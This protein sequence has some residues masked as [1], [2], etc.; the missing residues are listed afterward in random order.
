MESSS[1]DAD[2]APASMLRRSLRL[3]VKP[4]QAPT[5]RD[6][7]KLAG[8]SIAAIK[9]DAVTTP[10]PGIDMSNWHCSLAR[11]EAISCLLSCATRTRRA[12]HASSIGK[13]I[14]SSPALVASR[15]RIG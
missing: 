8:S 15:E 14:R 5:E 2:P 6:L 10:I 3:V 1:A 4:I 9:D 12:N 13:T 11:A 7:A